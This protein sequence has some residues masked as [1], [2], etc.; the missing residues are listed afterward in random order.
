[1]SIFT[2]MK[3]AIIHRDLFGEATMAVK[4]AGEEPSLRQQKTDC[5]LDFY[6]YHGRKEITVNGK[7]VRMSSISV[8]E[9][10]SSTFFLSTFTV[11][12]IIQGN[13]DKLSL[14]KQEWKDKTSDQIQRAMQK[15]WP[16][17]AW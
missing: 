1:M 7:S 11:Y 8:M 6:Y 10:V 5:I 16:H 9:L 12:D 3:G 17:L 14:M 13:G 4:T 2:L 15:K